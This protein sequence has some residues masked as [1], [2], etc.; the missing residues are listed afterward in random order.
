MQTPKGHV[1]LLEFN[2]GRAHLPLRPFTDEELDSLPH[3]IMTC[4]AIGRPIYTIPR[5]RYSYVPLSH[6]SALLVTPAVTSNTRHLPY[7]CIDRSDVNAEDHDGLNIYKQETLR[8]IDYESK[9]PRITKRNGS[10]ISQTL[11]VGGY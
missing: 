6:A 11:E 10:E 7:I 3:I 8:V 2:D 1:I 9:I 5:T 4:N